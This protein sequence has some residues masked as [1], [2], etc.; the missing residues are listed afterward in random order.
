MRELRTFE[1]NSNTVRGTGGFGDQR[2]CVD[3]A[4]QFVWRE[5]QQNDRILQK[6]F[7]NPSGLAFGCDGVDGFFKP[8]PSTSN[9]RV[10]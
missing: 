5:V 2:N 4:A 6:G 10:R 8:F 1:P 9:G 3:V 7:A